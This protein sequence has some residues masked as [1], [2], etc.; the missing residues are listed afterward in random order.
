M[1]FKS[2]EFLHGQFLTT[3]FQKL[4]ILLS[5]FFVISLYPNEKI[6][7]GLT[8][9]TLKEDIST[10]MN[11]KSYLSKEAHIDINLKFAKSYS[12][13]ES[14]IINESVDIAYVCGATYVDLE[15]LNKVE[16]FVIPISKGLKT[17]SSLIISQK[18]KKYTSLFDFKDK[19][20]AMSDPDS[21]S[22]SL[23]PFYKILKEGYHKD[24]F[25]KKVI[26][27]YDH[28]ESIEAV[29]NGF[30]DGASVDSMVYFAYINKH[31]NSKNNLKIVKDFNNYPIPPFI[32]RNTLDIKIKEKL[33]NTLLSMHKD[34]E[35][36]K[37]LNAMSID[38]FEIPKN[39][40]YDKIKEVKNYI[41]NF[42]GKDAQ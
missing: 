33:L 21:N 26:Y 10:I 18:D 16:L 37:I 12:I 8:G 5:F 41:Q 2:Y 27:T 32:I 23:L 14:F 35:G 40:S 7:L 31:P 9:V 28:G 15:D 1:I 34:T 22:G 13:I 25:F 24:S 3:K 20:F 30:V 29:L 42:R 11:F 17:Y 36:K 39:I 38:R 6:T 19:T 4:T